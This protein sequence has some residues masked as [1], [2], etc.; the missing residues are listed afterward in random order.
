[1][2]AGHIDSNKVNKLNALE[3]P[4]FQTRKEVNFLT[5]CSD[6]D[7]DHPNQPRAGQKDS[8]RFIGQLNIGESLL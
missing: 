3:T 4:I 5:N 7:S 1:M 6:V 2:L 8:K